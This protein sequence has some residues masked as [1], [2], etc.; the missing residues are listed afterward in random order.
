MQVDS[1]NP[2][3][4]ETCDDDNMTTGNAAFSVTTGGAAHTFSWQRRIGAGPW[5]VI[6]GINNPNDGCDYAGL[7]DDEEK[8]SNGFKKEQIVTIKGNVV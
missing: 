4:D 3:D 6:N 5:V 1:S 7:M 2:T 8:Q